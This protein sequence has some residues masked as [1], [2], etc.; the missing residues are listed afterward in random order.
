MQGNKVT[1]STGFDFSIGDKEGTVSGGRD[2]M[3]S[4]ERC[5]RE[6]FRI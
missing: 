6:F 4:D 5:F 2:A 3:G 1:V